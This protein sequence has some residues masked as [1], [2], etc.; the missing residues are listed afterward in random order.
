MKLFE[1]YHSRDGPFEGDRTLWL[2]SLPVNATIRSATLSL[3]PLANTETI[4]FDDETGAG[5]WGAQR[6]P[7]AIDAATFWASAA[8]GARRTISA[9]TATRENNTF[10]SAGATVQ[11]DIGGSWVDIAADGTIR[12][13]DKR[14]LLLTLPITSTPTLL[15]LLTTEKIKLTAAYQTTPDAVTENTNAEVKVT[16]SAV[17]IRTV[18]T[19]VSVRIGQLPPFWTRLGELSRAETSPDFT[20]MLTAYLT[21]ATPANG[22]YAIP[23]TLHSDTLAQV[24]VA[25]QI[26][27]GVAQ[28]VLPAYLPEVTMAYGFSTLP[29]IAAAL[30]TVSLP[31]GAVPVTGQTKATIRGEFQPTRVAAGDIGT[32]STTIPVLVSPD[33]SLA[34]PFQ[35]DREIAVTGV[36]LPLANT[37][38]GL[39]G[40]N[41]SIQK[42]TDGKPFGEVIVSADMRVEKP[43]PDRSS[44]GSAT[45]PEPFRLEKGTRYW[46]ILQSQSGKA[47]WSATPD[48]DAASMLHNSRDGGLSWRPATVLE[49][50]TPVTTRF[51]LRHTPDRFSIPIQLQLGEGANAVRQ[52]FNEFAPL[53]RIEFSFDFADKL[54]E[55]LTQPAQASPCGTGE[56]LVNGSFDQPP[57]T[58][59]TRRIFGFDCGSSWKL[60]S[61]ENLSL[62][63]ALSVER[64]ITLFLNQAE[65]VLIDCAGQNPARTKPN[66]IIEA[67]NRSMAQTIARNENHDENDTLTLTTSSDSAKITLM[68]WTQSTIPQGWQGSVDAK[69]GI[70]RVKLPTLFFEDSSI[71]QTEDLGTT[72]A[73][74]IIV[75][76]RSVDKESTKLS[77]TVAVNGGCTYQLS[78]LFL[79]IPVPSFNSLILGQATPNLDYSRIRSSI[80]VIDQNHEKPAV[81][82]CTVHW[83]NASGQQIS[84]EQRDLNSSYD[85]QSEQDILGTFAIKLISPPEAVQVEIEFTQPLSG[86]LLL[87]KVSLKPTLQTLDNHAFQFWKEQILY[88][89]QFLQI[90]LHWTIVKGWVNQDKDGVLL[91]GNGPED[92]ILSQIVSVIGGETYTLHV[93]ADLIPQTSNPAQATANQSTSRLELHWLGDEPISP[94]VTLSL[95]TQDFPT[96]S[97]AGSA[98]T[99]A[100]QAEIRI[101]Q[102]KGAGELVVESVSFSQL[103]QIPVPLTFLSEAPG[104]LTVS[105]FRITYDLSNSP[106]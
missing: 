7:P 21:T 81:P 18:P 74:R 50:P 93:K 25:L 13:P 86:V 88:E 2:R 104:T 79:S 5:N 91:K 38:P 44:W 47:Y 103:D 61:S 89:D 64:M 85:S 87:D 32:T 72:S 34:Q 98:P 27:Y 41:L 80:V 56:L 37:E 45:L 8:L 33:C 96:R 67:I 53:G 73:E 102:P 69:D 92:A 55:Y 106:D 20:D 84:H 90:P 66:E 51:R 62:G 30:M 76:L 14:P 94:S 29:D 71:N 105:A 68:P 97:W 19:N 46:L 57:H 95:N 15:P 78:F 11:V 40:V 26:D 28:L 101:I 63:V 99:V 9:V 100:T 58:D 23:F 16:L 4:S 48:A 83:L 49:S 39:A 43:L 82:S 59:A 31:R 54:R 17:Q 3:M 60:I 6:H 52:Q 65:P 75:A 1:K 36:D 12:T 10:P 35:L 22:F 42:D 70:W 24:E 77:Q